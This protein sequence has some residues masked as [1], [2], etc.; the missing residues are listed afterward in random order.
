MNRVKAVFGVVMLALAGYQ[1]RPRCWLAAAGA[2]GG[3]CPGQRAGAVAAGR[4]ASAR[5][6]LAAAALG[7]AWLVSA[8]TRRHQPLRPWAGLSG[9]AH[10]GFR[11]SPRIADSA[12]LDARLAAS[13]QLVLL[14]FYADWCVACKENGTETFPTQPSAPSCEQLCALAG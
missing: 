1:P 7:L 14:D 9:A 3:D 8:A 11:R 4:R 10:A 2:I 5:L 12:E 13:Q 6:A